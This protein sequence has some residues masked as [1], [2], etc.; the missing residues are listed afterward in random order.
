MIKPCVVNIPQQI[1][2][3]LKSRIKNT[4]WPDEITDSKWSY[5]ANLSYMKELADYWLNEF[6]WR[7]IENET[8]AYPN[9]ISNIDGYNIHF[10]HVKG[11]GKKSIP[12]IITHGWPG[13]FLEMMKLIPLLTTDP[14]F[15]FDVVIPSVIGFGFLIKLHARFVTAPLLQTCGINY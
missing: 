9:F 6:D 11:K 15:S 10:M 7:K 4:R 3:D 2:D 12:L 13:S 5:G 8:N 14:E 1:L